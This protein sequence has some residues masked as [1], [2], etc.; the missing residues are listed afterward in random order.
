VSFPVYFTGGPLFPVTQEKCVA[1]EDAPRMIDDHFDT[2]MTVPPSGSY[3]WHV[4]PSTRPFK[5]YRYVA[6]EGEQSIGTQ[7]FAPAAGEK[8][9]PYEAEQDQTPHED[10]DA[11]RGEI[12]EG[13]GDQLPDSPAFPPGST[14][15]PQPKHY[16][17]R[18]FT[19][20]ADGAQ[21]ATVTL[22]WTAEAEDY[23]LYLWRKAADGS[24]QPAGTGADGF[25]WAGGDEGTSG[26]PAGDFEQIDLTE[27]VPGEYRM[28]IVN[29]AAAGD[30]WSAK[31]ERFAAGAPAHYD[32]VGK[33][34]WTLT[35]ESADGATV[36]ETHE[37]FVDRG[38]AATVNMPCGGST[39]KPKPT[40]PPHPPKGGG[41]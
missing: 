8:P 6:G 15:E 33:E 7:E 29:F 41:R 21:R 2:T 26:H 4:T 17:E 30:D 39:K 13:G 22:N 40:K 11:I 32:E 31:V 20:P 10:Y 23:D 34:N 24:W 27:N 36:Y 5:R 9:A 1:P 37:V 12:P 14:M 19:I 28:R 18:D 38:Q 35:C 3:A 25:I 16:V